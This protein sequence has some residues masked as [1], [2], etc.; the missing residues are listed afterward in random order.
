MEIVSIYFVL[1]SII[2]FLIYYLLN[3]KYK[4][5]F[6]TLL[7][8]G[9]IASLSLNLLIYV[10]VFSIFNYFL[11]I[12]I[13]DS[14]YKKAVFR[15]GIF[16]NLLQLII[17]RYADFTISPILGLFHLGLNLTSLAKIIVPI[18]ISYFT[19]QGIGY[20][21]N[22]KMGWEKPEKK[23]LNFLLYIIF[24]PKFMSGPIER[25]NQFLPQLNNL[26][27]FN[28]QQVTSGLRIIL[29][30]FFKKD[31]IANQLGLIVNPVYADLDSSWGGGFLWIVTLI[32]PLY[33]Y[34]DF[35]GY[36]DIAIGVA[37]TFGISLR[38]N[39]DRPF[40]S[41]NVTTFWK[42]FHMSLSSW[43]ND[44]V[45]KQV[46]FKL[47][48]WKMFASVIAL[49]ITWMLFG[50]WH[51]AG[52]NFMALGLLQTLAISY[53]FFTK[54]G[55]TIIFSKI[56]AFFR[57]W[58]GRI[59]TYL[60]YGISLIFFYSP[61]LKHVF[62]YF[63]SLKNLSFSTRVPIVDK[64]AFFAAFGFLIVFM[65]FEYIFTDK[66]SIYNKIERIW[67]GNEYGYKILRFAFYYLVILSIFYF[68]GIQTE[69]IYFQF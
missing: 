14:P 36:T 32:Q 15:T 1:F 35:S 60:F 47:R 69:F 25:S 9:F 43:F 53:E 56:P 48:K 66:K 4:V 41:E 40:F 37:K 17:L 20:L 57:I 7:S 54:R 59:S 23:F 45:F 10:L 64:G 19:L 16:I 22:V 5:L 67:T 46:S 42:K 38:S 18:G 55:R 13:T 33:L 62:K 12:K 30:G 28:Q 2:S 3:Q 51:G 11:G 34:F 31:V 49:F 39:F 8:C 44:Y 24:F 50:I 27:S 63:D 26:K 29:L 21:I 68:G 58:I 61:D 65:I 6:L 52:W